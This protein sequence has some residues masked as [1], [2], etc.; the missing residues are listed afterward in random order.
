MKRG[1]R[2][3]PATLRVAWIKIDVPCAGKSRSGRTQGNRLNVSGRAADDLFQ[4]VGVPSGLFAPV[5]EAGGR[6]SLGQEVHRGMFDDCHVGG[7]VTGAQARQIIMEHHVQNP[8]EVIFDPPMT[9][10]DLCEGF[11]IKFG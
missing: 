8:M 2:G 4:V 7:A 9:A 3:E 10:P 11:G 5:F 1:A 6:F